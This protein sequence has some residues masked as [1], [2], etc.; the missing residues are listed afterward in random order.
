[1]VVNLQAYKLYQLVHFFVC[2]FGYKSF[3]IKNL[4]KNQEIWLINTR[5]SMYNIIRLSQYS[6]D[7]T[8][9]DEQRIKDYIALMS[10]ALKGVKADFVDIHVGNE[11]VTELEKF[12]TLSIDE[13]YYNGEDI[14][15]A[16]P[17]IKSVIHYVSNPDEEIALLIQD[18]NESGKRN[19]TKLKA[20]FLNNPYFSVTNIVIALCVVV[21]AL[22]LLSEFV[23]GRDLVFVL[24]ANYRPY[25][26][27]KH[28]FYRLL[29]YAF[30]HGSIFHL[31][32]NMYALYIMGNLCERKYGTLK[33]LIILLS[34]IILGGLT[35][36]AFAPQA[37]S[38]G[39][40]AGIYALFTIYIIDA[41]KNGAYRNSSF[42]TMV[43]LNLMLNFLPNVAWQAHLGGL[44]AGFIFYMMFDNYKV[45]KSYIFVILIVII[46]LVIK[47]YIV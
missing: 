44:V 14:Q 13:D 18:I 29:A 46:A 24:T 21:Y 30:E 42:M 9:N 8:F 12:K 5:N 45:N 23:F 34:A 27:Y 31:L 33:F 41:I 28:E 47:M 6:L 15:A 10:R 38:V 19:N 11:E 26:I 4:A 20:K 39:I 43:A 35:H 16:F 1:M 32:M 3:L 40:S 17:G 36:C 22:S 2:K 37:A 25:V 7:D